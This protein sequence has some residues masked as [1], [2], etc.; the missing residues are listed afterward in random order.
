MAEARIKKVIIPPENLLAVN[1][2]DDVNSLTSTYLVRYRI[3]SE[4]KTRTSSWSPIYE[5]QSRTVADILNGEQIFYEVTTIGDRLEI[6]WN[7]PDNLKIPVYDIYIQW[8]N[9][10]QEAITTTGGT[11]FYPYIGSFDA[12]FASVPIPSNLTAA[13]KYAKVWIQAATFPKKRSA[14][15]KLVESGHISTVYKINGGSIA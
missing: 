1:V 2:A 7:S 5:V 15:A 12:G 3:V 8:E 6:K 9:A 4:D 14:A 10:S 13:V 11:D